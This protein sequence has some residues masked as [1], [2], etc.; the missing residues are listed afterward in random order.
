MATP[1]YKQKT[2]WAGIAGIFTGIG[3]VVSGQTSEGVA[4]ILAGVQ[5]IFLR[6]A[7]DK[8]GPAQ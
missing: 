5:V 6:Q 2:F 4:A 8:S 7:V 3:L 1:I